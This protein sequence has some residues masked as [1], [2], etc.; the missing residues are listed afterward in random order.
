MLRDDVARAT[1]VQNNA[2]PALALSVVVTLALYFV[3]YGHHVAWPLV[4]LSTLAHELGHGLAALAV[5]GRFES[6]QLWADGS[7]VA[8]TASSGGRLA[9]AGVAAGGLLGPALIAALLFAAG[10]R[11]DTA[12][13]TLV[14]CGLALLVAEVAVVRNP[15]GWIFVGI[16]AA[17]LIAVGLKASKA[18][19]QF[20]VVFIAVQLSLSVFSR[21]DY[22]FTPTAQTARGPAPSDVAQLAQA[23]FLPYWFWGGLMAVL[24]VLV[25]AVG[26]WAFLRRSG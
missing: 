23:L 24:S 25:L 16:V 18:V 9:L 1:A 21:G 4:L 26:C 6:F 19:A 11:A 8:T 2:A 12:R 7:G 3:P 22:L 20:V 13:W 5:G 15:F 10:R 14:A 17:V